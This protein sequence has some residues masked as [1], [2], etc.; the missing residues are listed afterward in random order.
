VTEPVAR[1][2]RGVRDEPPPGS[3]PYLAHVVAFAVFAW[4]CVSRWGAEGLGVAAL[5]WLSWPRTGGRMMREIDVLTMERDEALGRADEA[6][7]HI[8]V[9]KAQLELTQRIAEV[10]MSVADFWRRKPRSGG[11]APSWHRRTWPS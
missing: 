1:M 7:N 5:A 8:A 9:L 10:A 11:C 2:P 3:R 4:A 6:E